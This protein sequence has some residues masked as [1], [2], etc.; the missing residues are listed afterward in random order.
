VPRKRL[1]ASDSAQIFCKLVSPTLLGELRPQQFGFEGQRA[2]A[3]VL[4]FAGLCMVDVGIGE[5]RVP[6][7]GCN[8]GVAAIC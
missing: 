4:Q 3:K 2:Q 5:S 8:S 1:K 6:L 7:R